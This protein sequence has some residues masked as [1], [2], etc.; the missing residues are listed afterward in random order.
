MY[1]GESIGQD[2][3]QRFNAPFTAMLFVDYFDFTLDLQFLKESAYHSSDK[4]STL[5]SRT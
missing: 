1:D 3:G 5:L 2:A 4:L